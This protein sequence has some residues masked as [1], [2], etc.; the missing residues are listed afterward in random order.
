MQG[1]CYLSEHE[2]EQ[3]DYRSKLQ[4]YHGMLRAVGCILPT[5]DEV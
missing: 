1:L 3:D 2:G 5:A 4:L